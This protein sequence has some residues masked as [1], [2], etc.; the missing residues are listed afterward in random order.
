MAIGTRAR[1][2]HEHSFARKPFY[3]PAEIARILGISDQT[4][5]ARIHDGK[6]FALQL[7]PR[8]YRIPLGALLQFLG[9][10]PSI[11]RSV[12]P[13]AV[14]GDAEDDELDRTER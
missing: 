9:E 4:V 8:L 13:R 1:I 11:S 14:V 3:A 2:V 10:P 6:L 5:L 12:D 7:G